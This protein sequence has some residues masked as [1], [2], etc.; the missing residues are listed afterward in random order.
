MKVFVLL[1]ATILIWIVLFCACMYIAQKL[2]G[3][4]NDNITDY[5]EDE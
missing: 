1:L 4:D 2:H 3:E 5:D